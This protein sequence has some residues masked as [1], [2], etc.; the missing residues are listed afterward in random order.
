MSLLENSRVLFNGKKSFRHLKVIAHQI[1]N[2]MAGTSGDRRTISYIDR[3]F[4]DLGFKVRRERF[5]VVTYLP[6]DARIITARKRLEIE[7][8]PVGLT[9]SSSGQGIKGKLFYANVGSPEYFTDEVKNKIIVM[10][11]TGLGYEKFKVLADY[12]PR[13]V[14]LIETIPDREPH[15]VEL[16]PEWKK[17]NFPIVRVRYEDGLKLIGED[18]KSAVVIC[19]CL[20]KRTSSYNVIT[21]L[22]GNTFPDEIIV[23]GAHHDSSWEGPGAADNAGGVAVVLELARIFRKIGSKRTLRFITW[24]AEEF[25]LKGSIAHVRRLRKRKKEI[26]KIKIVINIDVQGGLIGRNEAYIIGP[27]DLTSS[28]RLLA[29]EQGPAFEVRENI[30]SSDGMSFSSVGIPSVS[31][32]R[33]GGSTSY[34]HTTRDSIDHLSEEALAIQGKFIETWLRRYIVEAY[35]FPFEKNIPDKIKKNIADY[36]DKRLGVKI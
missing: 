35:V 34:L 23:I 28:V 7:G 25:G 6:K 18:G 12:R 13:A 22:K 2:R 5:N 11:A 3:T 1:K 16:M 17:R 24:G 30:Y 10:A 15:R 29:K 14:I 27:A 4:K 21:E 26:D 20:E 19:N 9:R 32:S 31:F 8:S 33:W 36:F